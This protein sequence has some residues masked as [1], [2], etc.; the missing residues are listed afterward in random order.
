MKILTKIA[1]IQIHENFEGKFEQQ[2]YSF[3]LPCFFFNQFKMMVA[4]LLDSE[5]ASSLPNFDGL[6]DISQI[7]QAPGP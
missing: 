2:I 4:V 5:T 1:K 7:Q 6:N 3:T